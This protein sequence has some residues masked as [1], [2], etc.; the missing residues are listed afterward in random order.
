MTGVNRPYNTE[1]NDILLAGLAAAL[2]CWTG[3]TG[4]S[5]NLEGHGRESVIPGVTVSRTVGWFTSFYPIILELETPNDISR[6][7]R[8]IKETLRRIPKKGIGYGILRYLTPKEQKKGMTF[9]HKPQINFNYLGQFDQDKG[10]SGE[11][12]I[13]PLDTGQAVNPEMET[14]H[15]LEISGITTGGSLSLAITFSKKEY[16]RNDIERLSRYY[17]EALQKIIVHCQTEKKRTLT[18]SDLTLPGLTVTQL[19]ELT[20]LYAL[21]K[22]QIKDIYPLSP[23]QENMLFHARKS[24]EKI[25]PTASAAAYFEQMTL[26]MEGHPDKKI[27]EHT[28][29]KLVERYDVLRTVFLYEAAG[30]PAQILLKNF[31]NGIHYEDLTHLDTPTAMETVE[32]FKK[33]DRETG[34][35]PT[36]GPLMRI[37]LFRVTR[38]T[39]QLIWS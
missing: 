19:E 24:M 14:L 30:K 5:V 1:I 23:M 15:A 37:A 29:N 7:I 6:I 16:R 25:S 11:I 28:Y 35:P 3:E 4:H 12:G 9:N 21:E 34:F 22:K 38:N 31:H 18:P 39:S 2:Y 33:E 32:Q 27:L 13:S 17:R 36:R 20:H 26:E 8:E 10:E